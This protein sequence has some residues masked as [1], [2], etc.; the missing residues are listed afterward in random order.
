VPSS[1]LN[2]AVKRVEGSITAF[3][4]KIR[5]YNVD[6]AVTAAR[7]VASDERAA[8]DLVQEASPEV[9]VHLNRAADAWAHIATSLAKFN[10]S[11][12]VSYEKQSNHELSL[13]LQV[14]HSIAC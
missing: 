10:L 1:D 5:V 2:A 6:G 8:A 14:T 7:I 3:Q 11:E 12:A 13:G 9:A 4:K